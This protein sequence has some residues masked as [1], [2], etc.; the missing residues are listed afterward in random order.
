MVDQ[1]VEPEVPPMRVA[2][3]LLL[4][5]RLA[6]AAPAP[7][8]TEAAAALAAITPDPK[9]KE[10]S[11]NA[12]FL[13]SDEKRHDLFARAIDGVGGMLVGV[14]TDQVW[15]L[16]AWA[17]SEVVIPMD[18][19]QLVV[20]VQRA[21]GVA[22]RAAPGPAE[23]VAWWTLPEDAAMATAASVW[24]LEEQAS[25][26]RGFRAA[27][28]MVRRKLAATVALHE[29][30]GIRSYLNDQAQ[31]DH[32]AALWAGGRVH[33]VRG[34]LTA[35]TTMRQIGEASIALGVPVRVLY[36]SNAE[37]YFPYSKQFRQNVLGLPFDARTVVLR[38]QGRGE[39]NGVEDDGF[40]IY[41]VQT[42]ESMRAWLESG[43]AW[44]VHVLHRQR[45]KTDVD[46]LFLIDSV[47]P[48]K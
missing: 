44:N 22:F 32:L 40:Y 48:S 12:H 36:L 21:Y 15:L 43:K 16:A 20:D 29:R 2:F 39:G 42:G 13:V 23:F 9:P 25:A 37:K 30:R 3:L 33:P 27:R 14:G 38:A 24:G 11:A 8:T 41:E 5:S 45:R 47:P 18:F 1:G 19:D 35:K 26:R 7:L 34:D 4:L 17:R 46:G 31:Y 6:V 10:L 28:A